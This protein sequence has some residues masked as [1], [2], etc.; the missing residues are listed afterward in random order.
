MVPMRRNKQQLSDE[1]CRCILERNTSGVLALNG[2]DGPYAV[3]LS[4]IYRNGSIIF[5]G[6]VSGYKMDAI[7]NDNRASFCVI[8][9]DEIVPEEFTTR[10]R[11]VIAKGTISVIK[12]PEEKREALT[13]LGMS[14]FPDKEACDMEINNF[15]DKTCVFILSPTSMT[16]KRGRK[17]AEE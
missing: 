4:Y 11:S 3:P 12:E 1:T 6:A 5:H 16:G 15:L 7:A 14:C 8:D 9:A 17:A 10:Y 13:A 2:E